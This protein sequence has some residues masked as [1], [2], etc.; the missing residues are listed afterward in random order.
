MF[1]KSER[2]PYLCTQD[3]HKSVKLLTE[4]SCS[5]KPKAMRGLYG[6]PAQALKPDSTEMDGYGHRPDPAPVC[7]SQNYRDKTIAPCPGLDWI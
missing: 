1:Y 5:S 4:K 7:R 2:E 6:G 3:N